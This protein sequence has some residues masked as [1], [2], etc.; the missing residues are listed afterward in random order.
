MV[1][2]LMNFEETAASAAFMN[3]KGEHNGFDNR[4]ATSR[5]RF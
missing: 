5:E 4:Q 3:H 2:L 1:Y